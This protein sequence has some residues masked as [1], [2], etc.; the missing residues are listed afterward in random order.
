MGLNKLKRLAVPILALVLIGLALIFFYAPVES[1][2]GVVQKIFYY[3]VSSAF[4]MYFGF[5]AAGFCSVLYLFKKDIKWDYYSQAYASVGVLFCSMVLMSGPLWARPVWGAWWSWDPRL[6]TTLILWLVFVTIHLLRGYFGDDQ[7]GRK[8]L[9][10]LTLMGLVD[11]PLIVFAVK[12]WRGV[13]PSVLGQEQNM[14]PEM[15]ITLIF[16]NVVLLVLAWYLAS[17][18]YKLSLM[19]EKESNE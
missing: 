19:Q 18:R 9:S 2:Q 14:P 12:L 3:H 17:L 5:I 7:R 16:N 1:T 11:I 13:H 4:A 10:L 15:K 8:I 6:T